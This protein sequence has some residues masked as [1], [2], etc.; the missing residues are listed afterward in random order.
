MTRRYIAIAAIIALVLNIFLFAFQVYGYV[1]FW[2]III[3][4]ALIAYMMKK[5]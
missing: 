3:V 5:R 4:G 2:A 1:V